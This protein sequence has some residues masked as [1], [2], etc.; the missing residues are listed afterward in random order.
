MKTPTNSWTLMAGIYRKVVPDVHH[1]LRKWK[2]KA[3]VIPNEELRNQALMSIETKT[4][5]C[6]G[7]G[8]Y[9]LLA[10]EQFDNVLSFIVAYQT[11]SDYLDN[12][13]DRS[14]SQDPADFQMLHLSMKHALT[15][16]VNR[17]NYYEQREDQDDNGYLKELVGTCQ[18]ALVSLPN[19]SVIAPHLLELCDYYCDLQVFKHVQ[20][21]KREELLQEWFT[22][23]KAKF[24]EM[25]WYE[26]SACAGSTLAIFCLVAYASHPQLTNDDAIQLKK[27]YFPWVQGLHILL[28]Y[29]IDQEEDRAGGDLNFCFY[30]PSEENMV[31]R[32]QYFIE[33]AK[34]S[35]QGLRDE[36]FH[37][38][39]VKG[40]LAIYLSDKKVQQQKQ[41]RKI[42][43]RLIKT[44]GVSTRFF[45]LNCK[46]YRS[47]WS[48]K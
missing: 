1:L 8:I 17:I 35:I 32:F 20:K 47:V 44:G 12:L 33:K 5:H 25:T 30:Y 9:G 29:F 46:F 6:V 13:C 31:E 38:L 45:F 39:I 2:E 40:L 42:A 34:M 36:P 18:N 15:P 43:R 16:G 14:T 4:F 27:S 28:D 26:F 23:H 24:P 48:S 22:K 7:G 10:K 3:S 41:V 11:I 19:Y 21:E 37:S